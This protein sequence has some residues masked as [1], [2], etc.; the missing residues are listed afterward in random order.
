MTLTTEAASAIQETA[1]Q[2]R[3][4]WCPA[5]TTSLTREMLLVTFASVVATIPVWLATYPPMVDLPEHAAQVAL[6]HNL[7]DPAFRFV[8]LFWVNWFTPYLFGYMLVYTLAPLVGIVTACKLVV[9]LSVAALPVTTAVLMRE[10][11]ADTYWALLTIPAMYGFSY[12]W[13]FLNFLVATP[14]G[15]LFLAFV[16]R[17]TRKPTLGSTIWVA[18]LSILLFFSHALIYLFFGAIACLYVAL[19]TGSLRK[20]ALAVSP[21]AAALPLTLLWYLRTRTDPGAQAAVVWDLGW[22]SSPDPHAW[23]GRLTGFFPRLLGVWPFWVSV[24]IG[25]AFFAL[26]FLAGA[27]LN[28]RAAAWAPL[29]I[30]ATVIMFAPSGGHSGWAFYHRF[31][32]FA[33]PFFVIGLERS[34]AVRP[35]WRV[36][37]IFLLIGWMAVTISASRLYAA[38]ARG[39]TQVLSAMQPGERALSLMFIKTSEASPAPVFLH[40]PAW[41]SA[42][43][44]GVVDMN[45]AVFPVVLVRYRTSVPPPDPTVSEWHPQTFRWR[46]WRGGDYRYFVVHAPLDLGYRLFAWAPC[47]VSLVARSDSWWLYEK[48]PR[49]GPQPASAD[50]APRP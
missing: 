24:A 31:T 22:L 36:A 12:N 2:A 43:K 13:G 41:Y 21:T 37:V 29:V 27:R 45:F 26:P 11:G 34:P 35:I 44:Q 9:A 38:E 6:L 18:L 48:D 10:T 1:P 23:G 47:P 42:T 3:A 17:H 5:N 19:E 15:L 46:E 49:C 7:H 25:I 50:T 40:F 28:R 32:V 39:F 30:C 4:D 33:L 14:I 20:A 16:I 8:G